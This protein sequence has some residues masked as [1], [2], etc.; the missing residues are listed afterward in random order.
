[1][2][3]LI[4]PRRAGFHSEWVGRGGGGRA[5]KGVAAGKWQASGEMTQ[6]KTSPAHILGEHFGDEQQNRMKTGVWLIFTG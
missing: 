3:F 2:C 6:F 4:H 5:G 1:M